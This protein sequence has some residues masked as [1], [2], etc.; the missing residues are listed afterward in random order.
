MFPPPFLTGAFF[1]SAFF[2]TLLSGAFLNEVGFFAGVFLV[3]AFLV[4]VFL[5]T[6]FFAGVFLVWD[7]FSGVFLT[8]VFL[9]GVFLACVF[10][11]GVFLAGVFLAGVFLVGIF[12]VGVFLTG[13]FFPFLIKGPFPKSLAPLLSNGPLVSSA[14]AS[15][16]AAAVFSPMP[17]R[18]VC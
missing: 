3:A 15:V 8:G 18:S 12:L 5:T 10:L 17:F 2:T 4:D 7:F 16:L 1:E 11:A 9:A 13:V 14:I 6:D